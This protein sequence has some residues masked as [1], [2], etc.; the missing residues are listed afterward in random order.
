MPCRSDITNGVRQA[1]Q[2][3]PHDPPWSDP[4]RLESKPA[5]LEIVQ[6][7]LDR[8]LEL[9]EPEQ[10]DPARRAPVQFAPYFLVQPAVDDGEPVDDD[11]HS[12][13]QSMLRSIGFA[14]L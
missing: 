2:A 10:P 1:G 5:G 8:Q 9:L 11:V 12:L 3:M 7:I 14:A 4:P 13:F 6:A